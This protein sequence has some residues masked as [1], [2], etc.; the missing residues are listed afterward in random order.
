MYPRANEFLFL[1]WECLLIV[2]LSCSKRR[3]TFK[4]TKDTQTLRSQ[5]HVRW[6]GVR[7]TA[8][9]ILPLTSTGVF[10]SNKQTKLRFS[11]CIPTNE[12]TNK[13]TNKVFAPGGWGIPPDPLERRGKKDS[14][15]TQEQ[16]R[17]RKIIHGYNATTRGW[18]AT[19]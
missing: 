3:K 18:Q 7:K 4:N 2:N 8:S 9:K 15:K 16:P 1:M 5:G 14:R 11:C 13:Q 17:L 10:V 6:G 19:K 12:Q